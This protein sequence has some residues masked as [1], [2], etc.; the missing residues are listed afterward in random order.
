MGPLIFIA[1]AAETM[2]LF[3]PILTVNPYKLRISV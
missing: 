1:S 3:I 2:R